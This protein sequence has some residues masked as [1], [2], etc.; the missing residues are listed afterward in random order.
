M[1]IS[2]LMTDSQRAILAK[3]RE[4]YGESNQ[5]L[6]SVEE[7]CELATVC[8]K[9]PRYED[10][11]KALHELRAKAID[12]VSDVLIV[13]DHIANI[14][15]LTESEIA[16]RIDGKVERVARWLKKSNSMQQ[17]TVDRDV[18][19]IPCNG[20]KNFKDFKQLKVSGKC[21]L[22]AKDGFTHREPKECV[23]EAGGI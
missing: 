21:Y 4:T 13:L 6:V 18:E 9:Y 3:A 7:L 17:T 5:I 14:F 8:T 12:E 22:C 1:E 16:T 19:T 2:R 23:D 10:K 20:C 15:E 11:D